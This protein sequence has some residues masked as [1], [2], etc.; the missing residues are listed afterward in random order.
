MKQKTIIPTEYQEACTFADWLR[1]KGI[2][3]T[4]IVNESGAGGSL[5]YGARLKRMGRSKGFPD[6][7]IFLPSL[8]QQPVSP[9][10]TPPHNIAIELK[11]QRGSKILPEQLCWLRLLDKQGFWTY[12]ARGSGEAIKFIEEFL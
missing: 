3:F 6:F 9:A 11:R 1:V 4:H 10:K 12:L 8:K 7:L 2:P 5:A